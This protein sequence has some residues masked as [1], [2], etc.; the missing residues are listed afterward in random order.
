MYVVCVCLLLW[1]LICF[2]FLL[3]T[4]R[5][6]LVLSSS[7][8]GFFYPIIPFS[9]SLSLSL[10]FFFSSPLLILEIDSDA[11]YI[12]SH[13]LSLIEAKGKTNIQSPLTI[14]DPFFHFFSPQLACAVDPYFRKK[15]THFVPVDSLPSCTLTHATTLHKIPCNNIYSFRFKIKTNVL[16]QKKTLY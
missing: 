1:I 3:Q 10:L 9:L 11:I 12:I 5:D 16:F 8:Y 4:T 2:L 14:Y 7:F 15:L 6:P 13:F